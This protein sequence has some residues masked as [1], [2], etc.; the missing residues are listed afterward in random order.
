MTNGSRKSC[1]SALGHLTSS[2]FPVDLIEVTTIV[3]VKWCCSLA[4]AVRVYNKIY[5]RDGEG[6]WFPSDPAEP[7][8][9][10]T[11]EGRKLWPFGERERSG[12]VISLSL[13][14]MDQCGGGLIREPEITLQ[15]GHCPGAWKAHFNALFPHIFPGELETSHS[16]FPFQLP[17]HKFGIIIFLYLYLPR[18][19]CEG[20]CI[21]N[22]DT[23]D[24]ESHIRTITRLDNDPSS[25]FKYK[26]QT[27]RHSEASQATQGE[28]TFSEIRS[29]QSMILRQPPK[30]AYRTMG[31]SGI[32]LTPLLRQSGKLERGSK[33][34]RE[35]LSR[36]GYQV[37]QY[38]EIGGLFLYIVV[39]DGLFQQ[40]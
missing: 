1:L 36:M 33:S 35:A 28:L 31:G 6:R 4:S 23:T 29:E 13:P 16:L 19:C 10:V 22:Y 12:S 24:M 17:I 14:Q 15:L 9:L 37:K 7:W 40:F 21:K 18:M 34:S 5:C 2:Q 25:D 30:R 38:S 32:K 27:P 3:S 39:A 26:I 8:S 20:K 11:L